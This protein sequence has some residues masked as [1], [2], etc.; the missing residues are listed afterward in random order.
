M[1]DHARSTDA[2]AI[3]LAKI[4]VALAA[5][6]FGFSHVSDDDYARTVISERFAI[7]RAR[8]ERNELAAISI[9]G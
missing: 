5:L 1:S 3:A 4:F 2:A 8:S 7:R 9:L 6:H